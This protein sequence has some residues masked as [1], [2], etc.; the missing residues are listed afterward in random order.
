MW[1]MQQGDDFY[2]EKLNEL[3]FSLEIV[4]LEM[5]V[6]KYFVYNNEYIRLTSLQT[7]KQIKQEISYKHKL[8]F[9]QKKYMS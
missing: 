7:V 9:Y 8:H 5:Y 1:S 2:D 3:L 4:L 6:M